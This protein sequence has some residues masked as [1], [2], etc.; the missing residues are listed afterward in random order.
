MWSLDRPYS[1][2]SV[3]HLN[4]KLAISKQLSS[5]YSKRDHRFTQTDGHG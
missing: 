3:A 1:V 2:V 4:N 5:S